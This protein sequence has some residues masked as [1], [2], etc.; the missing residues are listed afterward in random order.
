[1]N[2]FTYIDCNTFNITKAENY[3]NSHNHDISIDSTYYALYI[4]H[5]Y[6]I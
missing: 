1:M 6:K 2:S 5:F 3:V 4:V